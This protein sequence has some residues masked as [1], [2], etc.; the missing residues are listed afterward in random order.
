MLWTCAQEIGSTQ[1]TCRAFKLNSDQGSIIGKILKTTTTASF[2]YCTLK[3]LV[4][5]FKEN[6]T[7]IQSYKVKYK[8][9]SFKSITRF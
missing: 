6:P 4:D 5:M 2:R 1:R 3:V 9:L 8:V 7:K